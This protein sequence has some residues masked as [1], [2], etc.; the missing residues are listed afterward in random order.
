M[1]MT[2]RR[3]RAPRIG[4]AA[5]SVAIE[6]WATAPGTGRW[7]RS[8]WD[9]GTWGAPS[10]RRIDCEV[11]EAHYQ[12][13]VSD[14]AGILSIADSGPCDLTTFDPDRTLD[15]SNA[16]SPYF[17]FVGPGTPLRVKRTGASEQ[18]AWTGFI[19]EAT[20]DV[21]S[22]IG[23]I[24]CVDGI[25]Y[26][27]QAD[28]PEGLA[29]PNTLR[30]RVRAIVNAVGLSSIVPVQPEV[31]TGEFI[32]NGSFESVDDP[33]AQYPH[34]DGWGFY[35]DSGGMF[36]PTDV[37]AID[38]V[39]VQCVREGG[40]VA[41][42]ATQ[43]VAGLIPGQTYTFAVWGYRGQGAVAGQTYVTD[44]GAGGALLSSVLNWSN[45]APMVRQSGTFVAPASG[46]A[47]LRIGFGSAPNGTYMYFDGAS[48]VGPTSDPLPADPPV[49][50]YSSD[51]QSAW[52]A[53]LD[54]ASDA[55][56]YV[57]LGPSGTLR[58]T[59]WGAF[60]DADVSLGC[61]DP[62]EGP[63]VQT[64]ET[65]EYTAAAAGIRNQVRAWSAADVNT[66]LV[67]D[68][69]S[70]I[71]YGA[72]LYS[73]DRVVPAFATWA[74]RILADR[75]GAGLSVALGTVRPAS[76]LELDDLLAIAATGPCIVRVRDDSHPPVI[77]QDVSVIGASTRV[78]EV[79]W[80]FD[81]ATT[82]PR[83]EWEAV[84][85]TPPEPPIPPPNPWHTET[86][87]YVATSDALLALTS[88]G[89][90]YGAGAASSL[91]VG[92]WSG[93]QYRSL[94]QFP[95]IPWTK[96]RA[97]KTATLQ[98]QTSTQVR[99]G[100]G[101]SPTIELRRITGTWSAGSASAPSSGNAVVWP[102][103]ATTT[104]GLVR[105]NVTR[106]ENAGVAIR[107]DA[108]AR[109]WAPASAG[110]SGAAQRGIALYAGSGSTADT[111]ELW[112]VE[113]GGASRPT[114]VLELEVFD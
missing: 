108:I 105:A 106:S 21:V 46:R 78:T 100:F 35:P 18:T 87:Q 26:L 103:P 113:K 68:G 41:R 55:L 61:G 80:S 98:L 12:W 82:I 65:V 92:S 36:A 31:A 29:L 88:G 53:I 1:T 62:A 84:E 17:T 64:I 57:W 34:A 59:S 79:G 10:W 93:W 28:L 71:R 27:A 91:P 107:V 85:P 112:P 33:A 90:Q 49:A 89:S 42:Q 63:W 96:V 6:L 56:V 109:A 43:D 22:G 15:P 69:P 20:Y 73:V 60:P 19:D 99:V 30:A 44:P 76:E 77:D 114:L 5:G 74:D 104:S 11:T 51:E 110:G 75:A 83:V 52:S 9:G 47:T 50:P 13:G 23:R 70:V 4:P 86:R 95:S 67:A 32:A 102:G 94:V 7:D 101:S 45:A 24:R 38:G 16:D 3:P 58:F 39:R 97:V 81:F 25:A 14:E 111:S 72:R 48:I 8:T 66:A 40:T 2:A 37:N 54:A